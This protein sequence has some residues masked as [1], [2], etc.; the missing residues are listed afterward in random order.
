MSQISISKV[1]ALFDDRAFSPPIPLHAQ[2]PQ[3]VIKD[4]GAKPGAPPIA[5]QIDMQLIVPG[6]M[7]SMKVSGSATPFADRKSIELAI[8]GEGLNP[9][10]IKPYLQTLGLTS[11]LS[12]ASFKCK[13]S[14]DVTQ[15]AKGVM[16]ANAHL[17]E[18]VLHDA[19]DLLTL[20]DIAITG[21]VGRSGIEGDSHQGH[22]DHRADARHQARARR[23]GGSVWISARSGTAD[24]AQRSS[25]SR[26]SGGGPGGGS[27][28]ARRCATPTLTLP[29]STGGGENAASPQVSQLVLPRLNIDHF[30]W[31][32]TRVQITDQTV[33][34]PSSFGI[35]ELMVDLKDLHLD[36]SGKA[37]NQP[38]GR[39]NVHLVADGLADD[40]TITGDLAPSS[41]GISA[42]LDVAGNHLHTATLT[43]YL[44]PLGIE[45]L[46]HDGSLHLKTTVALAT[47]DKGLKALASLSDLSLK[48]GDAELLGAGS[49]K[50]SEVNLEPGRLD[51]G[52]VEVINPRVSAGRDESGAAIC[53]RPEACRSRAA[54]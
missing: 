42:N 26:Y 23:T 2:I 18:I 1:D 5:S 22:A 32:G 47:T 15:D 46:I 33:S 48:D 49:L 9:Q 12:D 38:P 10:L 41:N 13:L 34:P 43:P 21:A 35:S 25:P 51:V 20:D 19:A 30:S 39:L 36:P 44:R 8:Q 28:E 40:L 50:V 14:A 3:M 24:Y 31:K 53:R 4:F 54:A 11:L 37:S 6:V 45:P 52:D 7:R 27:V 29:R 16:T 17:H